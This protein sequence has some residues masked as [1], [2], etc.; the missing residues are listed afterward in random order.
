MTD[1][2]ILRDQADK[3]RGEAE[4][5]RRLAAKKSEKADGLDSYGAPEKA[6]VERGAAKGL[7]NTAQE[8]EEQA[9]ALEVMIEAAH[10]RVD[11]LNAQEAA[12][13]KEYDDRLSAIDKERRQILGE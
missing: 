7:E 11:E 8:H 9:K 4:T 2:K 10:K 12:L 13:R 5:L 6:G 3:A 1:V